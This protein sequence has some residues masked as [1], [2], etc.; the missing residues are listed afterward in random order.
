MRSTSLMNKAKR[1]KRCAPVAQL[2][3]VPG[4]EPGG[5][6]FE[7]CLAHHSKRKGSAFAGLSFFP[8]F[9]AFFLFAILSTLFQ[10]FGSWSESTRVRQKYKA[11]RATAGSGHQDRVKLP[12]VTARMVP[13]ADPHVSQDAQMPALS[14]PA[15]SCVLAF[16]SLRR[17]RIAAP[18][19]PISRQTAAKPAKT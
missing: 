8:D 7:S 10:L 14:A 4:Y 1:K 12:A 17:K 2:D 5:R 3:R 19:R 11:N 15:C 9:T 16:C 13:S 6:G 18:G